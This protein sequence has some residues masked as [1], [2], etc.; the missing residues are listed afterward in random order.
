M[1][2]SL[3][4]FNAP[5]SFLLSYPR[6]MAQL[7]Q[8]YNTKLWCLRGAVII[9]AVPRTPGRTEGPLWWAL[10]I[11]IVRESPLPTEFTVWTDKRRPGKQRQRWGSDLPKVTGRVGSRVSNVFVLLPFHWGSV[12]L[13]LRNLKEGKNQGQRNESHLLHSHKQPC[14]SQFGLRCVRGPSGTWCSFSLTKPYQL[15]AIRK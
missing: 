12:P 3:A 9:V 6:V 14:C 13:K 2:N 5:S 7:A 15:C 1:Q 10:C 11:H 8:Q 4:I